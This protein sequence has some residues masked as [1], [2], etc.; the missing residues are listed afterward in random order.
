MLEFGGLAV[1][2]GLAQIIAVVQCEQARSWSKPILFADRHTF[3][4]PPWGLVKPFRVRLRTQAGSGSHVERCGSECVRGGDPSG[5]ERLLQ[6]PSGSGASQARQATHII[7]SSFFKQPFASG[8]LFPKIP[9]NLHDCIVSTQQNSL[10]ALFSSCVA[11]RS[12]SYPSVNFRFLCC[13]SPIP[14]QTW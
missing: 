5:V 3:R 10:I 13:F 9:S 7:F 11:P 6:A 2:P 14:S 1:V 12:C 8:S 4:L